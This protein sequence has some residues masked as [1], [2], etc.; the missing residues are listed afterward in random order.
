MNVELLHVTTFSLPFLWDW[1]LILCCLPNHPAAPVPAQQTSWQLTVLNVA[2]A[3][4]NSVLS[5]YAGCQFRTMTNTS[6]SFKL[7]GLIGLPRGL[8]FLVTQFTLV[9]PWEIFPLP[10]FSVKRTDVTS[11]KQASFILCHWQ[12]SCAVCRVV[13]EPA[14][15]QL[16]EARV[17][18]LVDSSAIFCYSGMEWARMFA[19]CILVLRVLTQ[20]LDVYQPLRTS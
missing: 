11:D 15:C 13:L 7:L 14:A 9:S 16:D 6:F 20:S 8:W 19:W 2:C 12:A 4:I 17:K 3:Y 1:I 18:G 5:G 10:S